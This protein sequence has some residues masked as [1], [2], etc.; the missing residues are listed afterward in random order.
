MTGEQISA[1]GPAFSAYLKPF[2]ADFAQER[3]VEHFDAF[4]LG[5]LGDLPRKSVEPIALASGTAVRT[6]QAFLTTSSWDHNASR[7]RFQRQIAEVVREMP[8]DSLGV[9]GVIDETSAA[10]KGDKTPGVQRQYLGCVGK[11]DN[12]IVTVHIAVATGSFRSLLDAD[13]FLPESWDNDRERC[14]RAGIPDEIVHR[15]K[16]RIALE[17]LIRLHHNGHR[18][19][20]LT[21][22]EGYGRAVPFLEILSSIGQNFVAEVPK[23]FAVRTSDSAMS[24]RADEL[25]SELAAKGGERFRLRRETQRD[26]IWRARKQLVRVGGRSLTLIVAIDE[27]TGEVK[28]FVAN[29]NDTAL[30]ILLQV[31]F[32]RWTVEHL[33]RVAKQEV[34]LTHFEGRNYVGLMRHTIL[35]LLVLGF[36]SIQTDRL[37]GEKPTPDD[38]ASLS[39][40][41]RD[42]RCAD[43]SSPSGFANCECRGSDPLSSTAKRASDAIPQKTA[44]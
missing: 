10:K 8:R 42:L 41:E 5:L 36:V 14:E 6:L 21:F 39:G 27:A 18:F 20:W 40:I 44:A 2:R 31:A 15:S 35:C 22:D 4:C 43:D 3:S 30:S 11:V 38:G 19:D 9:I 32:R 34:G 1:L 16:W 12:G 26:Q 25:L 37:R 29:A 13:L 23:N 17:Q 24:Q 7:D 33:F 28:Y